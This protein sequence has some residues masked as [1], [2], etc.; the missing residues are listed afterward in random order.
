MLAGVGGTETVASASHCITR[1]RLKLKDVSKADKA[2]IESING[3]LSV[4]EA[5]GQYQVVIGDE[6]PVVYD[7]FTKAAGISGS[8]EVRIWR[9]SPR[10]GSTRRPSWW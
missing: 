3:V 10:P 9:R 2:K 6:V 5:G 7:Y 8:G 1:L 4:V